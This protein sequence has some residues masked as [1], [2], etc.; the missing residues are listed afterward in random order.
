MKSLKHFYTFTWCRGHRG[1]SINNNVHNL[2]EKRKTL[3]EINYQERC[4]GTSC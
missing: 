1:S 2:E 3:W 4:Y